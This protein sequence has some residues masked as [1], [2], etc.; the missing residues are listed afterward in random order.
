MSLFNEL[1][2]RN[3]FKVG[4]AYIIMAWLVMQVADVVLNNVEAP[5]WVFHVI[6]LL[7]GIGF[8]LAVFF[9]WAFELTP[10]G[11]KREHEVDRA[12]SITSQ[13][14]HNLDYAIIGVLVV[15]LGYFS[16]DK[17]VLSTARDAALVEATTQALSDKAA[18]EPVNREG[19]DNS[20]AV[21]PFVNMS[22]DDSNEFFSDGITEEVLNL[23]AKIPELRV[24]SRSSV[25]SLKGQN[26]DIPTVAK[27]LNVAHILEGS[28]RKAGNRVRI[29][30]QLI[31]AGSD[32]HMWSETFDRELDDIFAIQDEIATEVV[33]V[34]QIEILGDSPVTRKTDTRAYTAYLQG[35]HFYEL[36][37]AVD[38][39]A[40]RDAFTQAIEID[41][42]YAPAWAGLSRALRAMANWGEMDLHDGT[43]KARQ[44]AYKALELDNTL[45]DAWAS[46]ARIQYVYDWD[47]SQA[48]GTFRTALMY[49]P[50]NAYALEAACDI[51]EAIGNNNEALNFALQA[52]DVDPLNPGMLTNLGATYWRAG[53]LEQAEEL[54]HRILELY[55]DHKGTSSWLGWTLQAQGKP[56]EALQVAR[57]E[58]DETARMLAY[59]IIYYDLGNME[60]AERAFRYLLKNTSSF[61]AY[62]IAAIYAYKGDSD[63]TFEWLETSFEQRDGGI[64][65]LLADPFLK[66]LHEDPRWEP[67]LLKLGLLDYWKNL[68]ARR[69]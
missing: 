22:D 33:Q 50:N 36:G 13:T 45:A 62:Q 53:Q 25:F 17:L 4:I 6:L 56:E 10:E 30:A 27:K 63:K 41:P 3:V 23:L 69:G 47:W 52:V 54:F 65:H 44:A 28:V 58:S 39:I 12:L 46:L 37:R 15:A 64:T 68:Q 35:N 32:V 9:A 7:L 40:A 61:L 31:E 57:K 8:L 18:A 11:I 20:I 43:E 38:R 48:E 14:G 5:G 42:G 19:S 55:P 34:L 59:A 1:K 60:E 49:G 66:P 2:R 16:Y 67:Y 51:S 29:T 24:T 26:L 21:L